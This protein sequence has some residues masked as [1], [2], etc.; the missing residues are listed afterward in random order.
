MQRLARDIDIFV[1]RVPQNISNLRKALYSVFEDSSIE[2]ITLNELNHYAV[3]RYGTPNGFYIDIMTRL[4]DVVDYE[5]LE[6][7]ILEYQGIKIKIGT[8]ETLYHLKKDTVRHQD[9][10]D[11]MFLQELI[12]EKKVLQT[13]LR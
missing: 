13:S 6:Y 7:E 3:I 10:V 5:D 2:E 1:K 9:K 8:P 12:K 4:G 11:A